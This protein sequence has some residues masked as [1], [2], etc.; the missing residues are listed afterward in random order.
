M[1]PQVIESDELC[2]YLSL[3]LGISNLFE[4]GILLSEH[5]QRKR[6]HL[7]L[8]F[9]V[10]YFKKEDIFDNAQLV[11]LLTKGMTI[12]NSSTLLSACH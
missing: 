4:A 12:T 7:N 9:L 10:P 6:N 5:P 3:C 1:H 11:F 8:L 2:V